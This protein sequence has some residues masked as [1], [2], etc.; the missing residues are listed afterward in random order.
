VR[1]PALIVAGQKALSF[2]DR[3]L[4]DLDTPRIPIIHYAHRFASDEDVT[5]D[6]LTG[7]SSQ[8][9]AP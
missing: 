1:P 2:I 4:G 7:G 9:R 5:L 8:W 3:Y 6:L